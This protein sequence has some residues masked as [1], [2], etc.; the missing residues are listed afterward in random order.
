MFEENKNMILISYVIREKHNQK[1]IKKKNINN[2]KKIDFDAF[3]LF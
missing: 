2:F 1:K 3:I